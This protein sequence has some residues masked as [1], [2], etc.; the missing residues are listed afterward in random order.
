[1]CVLQCM[2]ISDG[3]KMSRVDYISLEKTVFTFP[4]RILLQ[5]GLSFWP[6][7][8]CG[9]LKRKKKKVCLIWDAIRSDNDHSILRL[10]IFRQCNQYIRHVLPLAGLVNYLGKCVCG[11]G[12]ASAGLFCRVNKLMWN[13]CLCWWEHWGW[14]FWMNGVTP[15]CEV[16]VWVGYL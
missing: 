6:D 8:A 9:W 1:M 4:T 10:F 11:V 16:D 2:R 3:R 13:A 14:K 15:R 5:K 7:R 12:W